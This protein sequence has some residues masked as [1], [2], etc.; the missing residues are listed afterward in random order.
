MAKPPPEPIEDF[1]ITAHHVT[2]EKVGEVYAALTKLGLNDIET[3]LVTHVPKFMMKPEVASG[4][5]IMKWTE[6]NPS[7]KAIDV[8]KAFEA[9]GRGRSAAYPALAVLVEKR[10]L[11][12]VGPGQYARADQKA[13]PAP[14]KEK[15]EKTQKKAIDRREV[16]HR[17]F[18]L[19]TASRNHGR[20]NTAWMKTQFEKDKRK[21]GAVSPSIDDLIKHKRLKRVASGEYVLMNKAQTERKKQ[22]IAEKK[23]NGNGA[24]VVE[25][26]QTEVTNG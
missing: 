16:N 12:K 8:V 9:D 3:N 5:F 26:T 17:E 1:S 20:F 21:P 25:S 24:P 11:K 19:R 6:D 7:F 10:F 15:Q 14:K 22:T 2:K 23:T 18:I 13:L 4:D